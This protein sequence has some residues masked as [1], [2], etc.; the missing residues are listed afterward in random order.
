[1]DSL[2]YCAAMPRRVV[3][4]CPFITE[5]LLSWHGVRTSEGLAYAAR[6]AASIR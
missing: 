4:L 6:L 5:T 2:G 3:S 1:M